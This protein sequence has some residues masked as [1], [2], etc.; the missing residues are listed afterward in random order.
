MYA[1]F[2]T[3]PL[4]FK[5]FVFIPAL[6]LRYFLIKKV[7]KNAANKFIVTLDNL[8]IRIRKNEKEVM[9]GKILSCKIKVVNDKLVY[10]DIKT[11]EDSI[12]FKARPKEYK[13]I[14]GNTS[15]NPFGTGTISDMKTVLALGRQ[16]KNTIKN[17]IIEEMS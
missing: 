2:K 16:I 6:Y 3:L 9:S 8:S 11:K 15:L 10:L 14:T 5:F 1:S 4:L 7:R 17:T 13:T 12:S